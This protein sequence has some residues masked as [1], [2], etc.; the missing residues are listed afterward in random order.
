MARPRSEAA[1]M[2]MLA[3]ASD[4]VLEA[5]V[6]GFNVDEIARRS[7]VAKT[8]IY[9]HFPSPNEL[10]VA[11]LDGAML[12]PP[13]PDTGSLREDLL[14]F[15]AGV[16]PIFADERIRAI[17]FEIYASAIRNPELRG[18]FGSMMARRAGPTIAIFRNGQARGEISPDLDYEMAFEIIE[19]PFIIRSLGRP[20]TLIDIDLE[21]LV[22]RMVILLKA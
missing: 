20:E 16:L 6:H 5:G 18:I 1:K 21:P 17:T 19:G 13:T 8:T 11:A 22:D 10:L 12:V 14:E 15:L 2:K 9:R 7:G 3:A 4:L